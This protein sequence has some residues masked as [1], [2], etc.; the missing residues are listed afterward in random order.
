MYVR[1]DAYRAHKFLVSVSQTLSFM[2]KM[3]QFKTEES[4][5]APKML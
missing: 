5:D 2:A 1:I 3:E 4:S